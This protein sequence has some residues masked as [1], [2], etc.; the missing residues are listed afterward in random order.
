MSQLEKGRTCYK[1][2]HLSICRIFHGIDKTISGSHMISINGINNDG[3]WSN[4]YK[5]VG[6]ACFEFKSSSDKK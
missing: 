6:N 2:K 1:C 5:A 4:I 3:G